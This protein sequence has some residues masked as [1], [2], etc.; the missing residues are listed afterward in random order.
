MRLLLAV[1]LIMSVTV[2]GYAMFYSLPASEGGWA[3]IAAALAVVSAV[4]AGWISVRTLELQEDALQPNI[5]I[6]IDG[7]SRYGMLQLCVCNTGGT[8]ARKINIAWDKPITS[9]NSEEITFKEE[10]ADCDI[11]ILVPSETATM[12][13]DMGAAFFE[14]TAVADYQGSLS[15]LNSSGRTKT[16]PFY[17]SAERFRNRLVHDK[18][19]PRTHFELQKIPNEL[20]RIGDELQKLRVLESKDDE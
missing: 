8:P 10:L 9:S 15:Y 7:S 11:E 20:K 4:I 19:A 1:T 14:V 18:E 13:I 16:Q 17:V 6:F 12:L 5:N 2:M 3:A